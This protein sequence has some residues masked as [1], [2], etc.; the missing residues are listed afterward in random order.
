MEREIASER[1]AR[2]MVEQHGRSAAIIADQYAQS[3]IATGD[4]CKSRQWLDIATAI[5][6][7]VTYS[8]EMPS[9]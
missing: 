5:R 1:I 8:P 2:E 7:S 6:R 4:F 3:Y 9:V